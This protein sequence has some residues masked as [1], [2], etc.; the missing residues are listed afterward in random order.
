MLRNLEHGRIAPVRSWAPTTRFK[1]RFY[2]DGNRVLYIRGGGD[3]FLISEELAQLASAVWVSLT[4]VPIGPD[5]ASQEEPVSNA[6][7]ARL[8][9]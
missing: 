8:R 2:L 9:D 3:P 5:L 7:P 1:T 6:L 4:V